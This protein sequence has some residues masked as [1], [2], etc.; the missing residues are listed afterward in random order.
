[1]SEAAFTP[2][3]RIVITKEDV[4]RHQQEQKVHETDLANVDTTHPFDKPEFVDFIHRE[5]PGFKGDLQT[6][7]RPAIS[8][9]PDD[10]EEWESARILKRKAKMEGVESDPAYLARLLYEEFF[11]VNQAPGSF[12]TPMFKGMPGMTP[13][14]MIS[15][16]YMDGS[17]NGFKTADLVTSPLNGARLIDAVQ[18]LKDIDL[19]KARALISIAAESTWPVRVGQTF[20]YRP[21]NWRTED[22]IML[23]NGNYPPD[24]DSVGYRL[25]TMLSM[26]PEMLE[27]VDSEL[28]AMFGTNFKNSQMSRASFIIF[29]WHRC[30]TLMSPQG[31]YVGMDDE[32]ARKT[33]EELLVARTHPDLQVFFKYLSP[34]GYINEVLAK[35]E[36]DS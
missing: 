24:L 34:S 17:I 33:V 14:G 20:H 28:L 21:F 5:F 35:D 36:A 25:L 15:H 12:S 13:G 32:K 29:F 31:T 19:K 8:D 18:E 26:N 2:K 7:N 16:F 3:R 1:M 27:P 11:S 9:H 30:Q 10:L 4:E 6:A 22:Q 23:G